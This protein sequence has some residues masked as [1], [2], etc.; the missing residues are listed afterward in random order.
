MTKMVEEKSVFNWLLLLVTVVAIFVPHDAVVVVVSAQSDMTNMLMM[1]G[2]RV[3]SLN[4]TDAICKVGMMQDLGEPSQVSVIDFYYAIESTSAINT[5]TVSGRRIIN[6]LEETI[7]ATTHDAVLWCYFDEIPDNEIIVSRSSATGDHYGDSGDRR[8]LQE[9][10]E[11]FADADKDESGSG[12]GRRLS[13]DA[14]R[15]LSIV[16]YSTSPTDQ[17]RSDIPCNFPHNETNHCIVMHGMVTLVHQITSDISL[18]AASIWDAT[19]LVMAHSEE[20]LLNGDKAVFADITNVEWL[21]ETEGDAICGGPNGTVCNTDDRGADRATVPLAYAVTVPLLILLAFALLVQRNREQRDVMTPRQMLALDAA[22]AIENGD[23]NPVYVGTGDPPRSFHEGMY[24][25]T[26]HGARYLSTN[27]PDCAETRRSGFHTSSN[28]ETISEEGHNEQDGY[29]DMS[30][31][32]TNTSEYSASGHRMKAI[33]SG[34][35]DNESAPENPSD[36]RKRNLVEPSDYA[37]GRKHSSIDVHQCSSATCNICAYKPQ[38][39]AFVGGTDDYCL[40]VAE[41]QV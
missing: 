22:Y 19:E 4:R 26:R 5:T 38:N 7:F 30:L 14:A 40:D 20:M 13:L 3:S 34:D 21:G 37:L 24:H 9:L 15:R 17:E 36:H 35:N 11:E 32:Y 28:L 23:E 25:Y 29:D 31:V 12:R 16:S 39:V 27:C 18:V 8:Q 2:E 6:E 10:Q 1:P 41:R 33:G